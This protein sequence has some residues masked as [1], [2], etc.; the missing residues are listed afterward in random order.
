MVPVFYLSRQSGDHFILKLFVQV[1]K[2]GRNTPKPD[3]EILILFRFQLSFAQ[4][5]PVQDIR[6]MLHPG[7]NRSAADF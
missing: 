3:N 2:V 1:Y 6:L 5:L 4:L 7:G